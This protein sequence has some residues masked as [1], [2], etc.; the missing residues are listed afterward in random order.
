MAE[1]KARANALLQE[2]LESSLDRIAGTLRELGVSGPAADAFCALVRTAEATAAELVRKT[3]IPDSKIYYALD[4]LAE[5]GLVEVQAGKPKTFRVVPPKEVE[6]RLSEMV[7]AEYDRRRAATVRVTSLLEPLRAATKAPA[8]DVAYIVKGLPNIV[9]RARA[10]IGSARKD[11]VFL[12]SDEAVF[13][14]LEQDLV[15]TSRRRVRI[16]LAVPEMAVAKELEKAAE[17]R[18]IICD[19]MLLVADCQQ[20]LTMSRTR[21]GAAHAMG[22]TQASVSHYSTQGRR[23]CQEMSHAFPAIK[24]VVHG[25]AES[26]PGGMTPSQQI[27]SV[28][29]FCT[30]RMLTARICEYHKRMGDPDPHCT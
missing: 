25:H 9:A 4:E 7:Q 10:L 12:A 3:G 16:R 24:P 15:R 5:K 14:K 30:N 18:S 6:I 2:A 21:A 26:I 11:V 19:C 20:V 1:G 13:R 8:M 29:Q 17:V 28:N 27:A 23:V 22:L